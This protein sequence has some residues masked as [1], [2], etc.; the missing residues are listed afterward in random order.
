MK[1]IRYEVL[2][3]FVLVLSC[4]NNNASK[5]SIPEE[6]FINLY[7]DMLILR[8]DENLSQADSLQRKR[9]LDSLYASYKVSP[10]QFD[11]SLQF[12]K[13]DLSRW[14]SFYEEVTQRLEAVQL[15]QRQKA[16]K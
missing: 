5:L 16:K 2:I 7:A 11:A 15:E 13:N 4:R 3:T 9:A 1:F 12:Y 10:S 8:E 6:Q 14:K